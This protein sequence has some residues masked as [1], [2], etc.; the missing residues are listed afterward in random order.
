MNTAVVTKS[1]AGNWLQN[2]RWLI[3]R[4]LWE[5]RAIYLAP[6]VL[7]AIVVILT[8]LEVLRVVTVNV[9]GVNVEGPPDEL[10]RGG[11]RLMVY[12]A[13]A[14]P[15]A[16]IAAFVSLYYA[17]DALYADRR[18]RSLLFWKSLPISDLETVAAKL[19]IAAVV[20][21]GI[22]VAIS[23]VTQLFAFAG[24]SIGLA[25]RGLPFGFLW[26]HIPLISNVTFLL[27]MLIAMSLWY[28]PIWAWCLLVS[29]WARRAPFLWAIAPIAAVWFV[30]YQ[31]FG[32][33]RIGQLLLTR[34]AGVFQSATN[35]SGEIVGAG[36]AFANVDF[37]RLSD[38]ITPARLFASGQLWG[39]IAVAAGLVAATVWVRRYREA[40]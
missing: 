18:D 1:G 4:E 15:F 2:L 21:P 3:R 5:H 30:D 28:L 12:A 38:L 26:T 17:L 37:V 32:T 27:Y 16:M 35:I 10:V 24:T 9:S 40:N 34:L 22:A 25:T 31:V 7:S 36:G 8:L 14:V 11:A 19:V 23:I 13:F 39:G 33:H 20:V 6:G 29:A